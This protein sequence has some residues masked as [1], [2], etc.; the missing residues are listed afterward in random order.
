[1]ASRRQRGLTI[2]ELLVG[3]AIGLFIVA[4]ATAL[5]VSQLQAWRALVV[6]GRLMQDLGVAC[7]VITRDLRRA[8]YWGD[9][10]A[11]AWPGGASGAA[12]N[13]YTALAPAAAA[14]D[15]VS[16]RFSRDLHA[17]A[18]VD[19][20]EQ[21]GFRLR[22]GVIEMM[23]GG[24]NWQALTDPGSVVVTAFSVTP[25]LQQI[26]LQGFCAKPCPEGAGVCAPQ[27]LVRSLSVLISARSAGGAGV[28]RTVRTVRSEVQLRNDTIVGA[29]R[30]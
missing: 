14:S 23:L 8:G 4:C 6:Q 11:S 9:A 7:D 22:H 12:A 2:V 20:N 24:G 13:P 30:P 25:S 17:G 15:A 18:G 27:Q 16:F 21:F 28:V 29:C 5:L 19:A 26:A 1:M 3:L 10:A